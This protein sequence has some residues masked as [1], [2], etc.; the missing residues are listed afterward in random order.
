MWPGSQKDQ[1]ERFEAIYR[2]TKL[3]GCVI[4]G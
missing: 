2:L 4:N 1:Q 3:D